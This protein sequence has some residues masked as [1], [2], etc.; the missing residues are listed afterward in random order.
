M[1][2]PRIT[3]FKR[4]DWGF[5][6]TQRFEPRPAGK[7]YAVVLGPDDESGA[8]Q[9]SGLPHSDDGAVISVGCPW[10]GGI[11]GDASTLVVTPAVAG[12]GAVDV[13]YAHTLDLL[14]I[15]DPTCPI[16]VQRAPLRK[17][18]TVVLGDAG[19]AVAVY[20]RRRVAVS[21]KVTALTTPGSGHV[22][23]NALAPDGAG[24][25]AV[26][27]LRDTGASLSVGDVVTVALGSGDALLDV[28]KNNKLW[29]CHMVYISAFAGAGLALD[30]QVEGWD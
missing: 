7:V 6:T 12:T 29:P 1:N 22:I 3:R 5:S 13:L 24:A 15:H 27:N 2:M 17:R 19:Y 16:P 26:Q 25:G 30:V 20:G 28:A 14:F 18:K 11:D 21:A 4:K 23:I 8:V 9:L 10:I